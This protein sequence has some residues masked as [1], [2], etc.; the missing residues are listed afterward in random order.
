MV[1]DPSG[2]G[3]V[4]ASYCG[5]AVSLPMPFRRKRQEVVDPRPGAVERN[6]RNSLYAGD[7]GSRHADEAL[8]GFLAYPRARAYT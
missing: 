4:A 3:L 5:P 2:P 1:L 8:W 7:G 6:D